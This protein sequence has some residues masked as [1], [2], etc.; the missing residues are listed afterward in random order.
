MSRKL[1]VG[2]WLVWTVSG[3]AAEPVDTMKVGLKINGESAT[4]KRAYTSVYPQVVNHT[5]V[6][7][8]ADVSSLKPDTAHT[9]ELELPALAPGQFQGLFLENVEAEY[10]KDIASGS[11]K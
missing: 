11:P 4:L 8:Y 10:T 5:F 2:F 7:W 3:M 6:G 9:F 1:W